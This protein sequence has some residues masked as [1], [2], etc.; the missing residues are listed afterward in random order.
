ME[1]QAWNM[2]N[3]CGISFFA[4]S[5]AF[6]QSI[7]ILSPNLWSYQ[8]PPL[9]LL[10]YKLSSTLPRTLN[11][12]RICGCNLVFFVWLFLYNIHTLLG[13]HLFFDGFTRCFSLSLMCIGS[14]SLQLLSGSLLMKN[15]RDT[16]KDGVQATGTL[17]VMDWLRP[18]AFV[19][20]LLNGSCSQKRHQTIFVYPYLHNLSKP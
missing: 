13:F 10:F 4:S 12:C 17:F 16:N 18:C 15:N 19:V 6:A 7:H 2:K 8:V 1:C 3:E 9:A 14:G 20:I 5:T 11:F